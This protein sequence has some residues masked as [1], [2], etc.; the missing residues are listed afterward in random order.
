MAEVTGTPAAGPG[1]FQDAENAL[2]WLIDAPEGAE[3]APV[4]ALLRA[5]GA[6]VSA[7]A[8]I[9]LRRAAAAGGLPPAR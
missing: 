3:V 5:P 9:A 6:D 2:R 4:L 1:P 7:K 8:A